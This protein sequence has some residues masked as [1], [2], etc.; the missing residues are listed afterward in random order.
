MPAHQREGF[1]E[2]FIRK[3]R[4]RI[5]DHAAF[6]ALD[7]AN[8]LGLFGGREIA[9]ND[10]YSPGLGKRDGKL[11]LG[12][13]IHGRRHNRNVQ[14]ERGREFRFQVGPAGQDC[15]M[16]RQ[17]EHI[18]ESQRFVQRGSRDQGQGQLRNL[19]PG[20]RM[21]LPAPREFVREAI[22]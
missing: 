10:A 13:R 1:G 17:K 9:M 22:L 19:P 15:R 2:R 4:D 8:L 3:N 7:L 20:E 11:R 5:D 21:R 6:V 12:D 16:A 18:I 14:T